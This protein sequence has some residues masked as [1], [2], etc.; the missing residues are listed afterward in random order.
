MLHRAVFEDSVEVVKELL[1]QGADPKA[2]GYLGT[3]AI[4]D[5]FDPYHH[6]DSDMLQMGKALIKYGRVTPQELRKVFSEN[7][8]PVQVCRA[9]N[10]YAEELKQVKISVNSVFATAKK[11]SR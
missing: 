4:D 10:H 8:T 1:K 11:K 5:V 9:L 3:N 2:K 6:R 7:R